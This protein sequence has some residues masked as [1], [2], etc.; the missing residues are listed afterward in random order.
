VKPEGVLL[1]VLAGLLV[2]VATG[3]AQYVEDSID[4]GAGVVGSLVYNSQTDVVYGGCQAAGVLFAISCDSNKVERSLAL[5]WPRYLDYDSTDNKCY[6]AFKGA[7]EDSLA[8]VDGSTHEIARKVEV[9][10]AMMPV[11]DRVSDRL[12]VSCYSTNAVAVVDCATDSVLT[13]IPVGACPMKMYINTLRRKLYVLNYDDGT[14]SIVNMTTNQVISTVTTSAANAGYYCRSAD[15]FYCS[16]PSGQ[17]VVIGGQ[18]DTIVARVSLPG[19]SGIFSAIGNEGAGLVY[20]GT[21][22]TSGGDDYVA[23]VSVQTD[24]V[25]A[26]VVIGREPWGMQFYT[27]SGLLYC[28]SARTDEVCVLTGDGAGIRTTLSVGDCPYVFA[29]APRHDRLYVGHLNGRYVYVLRDTSAAIAESESP[30]SGLRGVSVMP[31]PFTQSAVVVWPSP[32]KEGDAARVFAQDGRLV[33][34][35]RIP[36]GEAR[37]V[38][39]GRDSQGRL[40]P[41]GVYVLAAPGGV[42]TKAIKLK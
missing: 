32:A 33:T 15:K 20:L 16:G 39:D 24:S 1:E 41:P 26:T 6:V 36:A 34:Q 31:N 38:W 19:T 3:T 25:L 42:R 10:G 12:Y 7:G 9:P 27:P 22:N 29:A 28:A 37:W 14:V 11:W 8:V 30:R 21:A 23:T 2:A 5:A 35:A 18:C 17:C 4:V 40:V 13:Y